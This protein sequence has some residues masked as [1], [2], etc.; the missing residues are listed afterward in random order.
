MSL[1]PAPPASSTTP[2]SV[3]VRS[4]VNFFTM[5]K[6]CSLNQRESEKVNPRPVRKQPQHTHLRKSLFRKRNFRDKWLSS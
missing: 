5:R 4:E 6:F 2:E 3:T 1:G